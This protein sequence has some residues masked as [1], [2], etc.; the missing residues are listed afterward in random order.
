MRQ[1]VRIVLRI[2]NQLA[3]HGIIVDISS[4]LQKAACICHANLGEPI[5][6]KLVT[7]YPT[8]FLPERKTQP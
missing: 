3:K 7:S 2:G 1:R 6:A 8:P 4:N 5:F